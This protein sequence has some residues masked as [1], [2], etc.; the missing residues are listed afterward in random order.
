MGIETIMMAEHVIL[1][2]N[3]RN[4]AEAVYKAVC[5]DVTP[6]APASILQLH[7]DVALILEKQAASLLPVTIRGVQITIK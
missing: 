5:G 4:K 6:E 3:G 7:R 1:L 2:A